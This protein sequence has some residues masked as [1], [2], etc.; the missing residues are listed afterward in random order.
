M[1]QIL[2][3]LLSLFFSLSGPVTK[4]NLNL[5]HSTLAAEGGT[6]A[7]QPMVD[8]AF[9]TGTIRNVAGYELGGNAGLVALMTGHGRN[10]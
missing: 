10:A 6:A 5:W 2:L 9:Q 7:L 3:C 1:P 4:G 8:A